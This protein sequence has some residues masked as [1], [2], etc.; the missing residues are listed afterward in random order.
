MSIFTKISIGGRLRLAFGSLIVASL[1]AGGASL[2]QAA[3]M[4]TVAT[5]L[6]R[7]AVPSGVIMGDLAEAIMGFRTLQA[8]AILATDAEQKSL[9]AKRRSE[10]LADIQAK[11]LAYVPFTDDGEEKETII[12]AIQMAWKDYQ[13]EDARLAAA[14]TDT[15]AAGHIYNVELQQPFARLR[16]ALRADMDYSKRTA[17][18]GAD[19]ADA[20]FTKMIWTVGGGTILAAGLAVAWAF[21]LNRNVTF[22]VVRLAGVMR[23]LAGRDYA[24]DLPCVARADEIGDM[25]RGID[26]C[27]D[28]LKSADAIAATQAN[29]QAV[30]IQR[31]A[32]LE[33]LTRSKSRWGKWSVKCPPRPLSCNP[34]PSR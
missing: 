32:S 4:A 34:P 7:N 18:A 2:Y 33:A 27:R 22:R 12:P 3:R 19:N 8:A 31:A 11:F 25:A 24:F 17:N 14:G 20:A 13:V 29:E 26:E 16:A 5:D 23:Q 9:I 10:T 30:K 28:G 6:G 1:L 21:W 15:A